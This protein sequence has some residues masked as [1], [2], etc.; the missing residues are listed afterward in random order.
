MN[1]PKTGFPDGVKE[2]NFNFFIISEKQIEEKADWAVEEKPG[3]EGKDPFSIKTQQKKLDSLKQKKREL[4]NEE[5]G[6]G[7]GGKNKKFDKH[8]KLK[9]RLESEKKKL[10]KTLETG[11][12]SIY[13]KIL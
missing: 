3:M 6:L 7:E 11:N 4:R 9:K 10:D 12:I 5:N 8:D 13:L 1:L 2:G